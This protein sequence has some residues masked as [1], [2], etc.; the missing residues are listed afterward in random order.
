MLYPHPA[1][2]I[3]AQLLPQS[4]VPHLIGLDKGPGPSDVTES[5][6]GREGACHEDDE[7]SRPR[8]RERV[9]PK[10]PIQQPPQKDVDKSR[11]KTPI[12]KPRA[13]VQ[14]SIRQNDEERYPRASRPPKVLLPHRKR[15]APPHKRSASRQPPRDP[16]HD[17]GVV[18]SVPAV[19]LVGGNRHDSTAHHGEP[20]PPERDGVQEAKDVGF[21]LHAEEGT[22][23]PR[24]G[25]GPTDVGEVDPVVEGKVEG[26]A[27]VPPLGRPDLRPGH[28][29]PLHLDPPVELGAFGAPIL[30]RIVAVGTPHLVV[31]GVVVQGLLAVGRRDV[32]TRHD[33]RLRVLDQE[34]V[35]RDGR[36]P[37]GQR[38]R[39]CANPHTTLR[40]AH[41]LLVEHPKVLDPRRRDGGPLA[42]GPCGEAGEAVV[43]V[44]AKDV[45]V[46]HLHLLRER[47]E[48][49]QELPDADGEE[50]DLGRDAAG[51]GGEGALGEEEGAQGGGVKGRVLHFA[52]ESVQD[53]AHPQSRHPAQPL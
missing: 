16:E 34:R 38:R 25:Q 36:G 21:R 51:G 31:G 13:L 22:H 11:E 23:A 14:T 30:H 7:T 3:L 4:V 40:R 45:A 17:V 50:E 9:P 19:E 28:V 29:A 12:H 8:T 6:G 48:A 41:A 49:P 37:V 35:S 18:S 43:P 5:E 32:P 44:G 42:P 24:G 2:L 53:I 46:Q 33:D 1:I 47:G 15:E 26:A 10:A 20:K 52:P 27:D 39:R